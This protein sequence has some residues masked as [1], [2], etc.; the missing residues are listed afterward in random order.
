MTPDSASAQVIPVFDGHNDV[1]LR[2]LRLPDV[3]PVQAFLD[4]DNQGH[5]DLPRMRQGGFGGGL[6]AL[7]VPSSAGSSVRFDEMGDQG[8]RL[9]LPAA[10]PLAESLQFILSELALL[11]RI[12]RHSGGQVRVCVSVD[13]VRRCLASGELAVV[14]HLEGA[15]AIDRNLDN[16][17]VLYD[18]GLRSIGPVWS[19]PTAFG[20]G[21]PFRFPSSPDTGPGLTDAGRAL[22]RQMNELGM[23]IDL[24]HLNEQGFRDVA[25]LST[26]PL[27]A[28]HSNA[29]ALCRHSRNLT[30]EQLAVIRDSDGLVGLNFATAFLREDGR[31]T[32]DTPV[33]L[34]LR[35]LDYLLEKLGEHGVALGSDF[36]GAIVPA[37]IGDVGGLDALRQAMHRHGYDEALIRRLCFENWL[38][39]LDRTIG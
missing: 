4:G 31:M 10:E 19:R 29:W 8:Y 27:V 17:Q 11:R 33:S 12:E 35:H 13:Q 28:T 14:V 37:D 23:L 18:A 24:S 32:S 25:R 5:L 16:L 39:V 26:A 15:E 38:S 21:V 30:D 2:L 20:H 36:D 1:L 7:Y 9:P 22:V 6:F 3:D 34:M